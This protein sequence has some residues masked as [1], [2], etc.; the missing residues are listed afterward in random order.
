MISILNRSKATR[1]D[2]A[3]TDEAG[4]SQARG[5]GQ[6]AARAPQSSPSELDEVHSAPTDPPEQHGDAVDPLDAAAAIDSTNC[7]DERGPASA[8][9]SAQSRTVWRRV[10]LYSLPAAVMIAALVVGYLK[11]QEFSL[12]ELQATRAESVR[13]ATDLTVKMLSYRPDTVDEDLASARDQMT[14]AFRDSY[15]QLTRDVVIPGS[16]QKRISAVAAVPAAASLSVTDSRAVVL[17]FVNQSIVVGDDAPSS[18]TSSVK[19]TLNRVN[20]R[21]LISDFSPI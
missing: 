19:V 12:R 7:D 13:A 4:S 21:W 15:A 16:K 2:G 18:T 14:G 9:N 8:S 10:L 6:T 5:T 11:W 3:S 17:V 20:N 1:P